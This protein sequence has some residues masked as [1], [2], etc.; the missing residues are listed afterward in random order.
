MTHW[1]ITSIV[2]QLWD[3]LVFWGA[4]ALRMLLSFNYLITLERQDFDSEMSL[5]DFD[6]PP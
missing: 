3:V 5:I 6:N 1:E 4:T 2:T